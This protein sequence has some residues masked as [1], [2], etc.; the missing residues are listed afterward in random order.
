M[1]ILEIFKVLEY[2]IGYTFKNINYL[3]LALTHSSAG[4]VHNERLEFL[5]DS[6][7][8]Y[9]FSNYLYN[10]YHYLN[11]GDLSRMRAYLVR[12]ATLV[13]IYKNLGLKNFV[14]LGNCEKKNGGY[15]RES[16]SANIVESIIGAILLDSNINITTN[17]I[18][19][20]FKNFIAK[21]KTN[22]YKK[23]FKTKLQEY[24]QEYNLELPCYKVVQVSGQMHKQQFIIQCKLK[25]LPYEQIFGR[26]YSKK[27]AEQE[28]AKNALK[29]L[30]IFENN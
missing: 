4:S 11:E 10:N 12:R 17:V 13:T 29:Q 2:N 19:L 6:V 16:I 9:C 24:L 23:D 3:I 25:H 21:L 20:W 8:N 26:G 14:I 18:L 15:N 27:Q 7:I 30:G 28:S 5:G 22:H 1:K